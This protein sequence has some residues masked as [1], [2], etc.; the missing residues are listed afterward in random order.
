MD[1]GTDKSSKEIIKRAKQE[2]ARLIELI[3]GYI[4]D[5]LPAVMN[6]S[7]MVS[8]LFSD[9]SNGIGISFKPDENIEDIINSYTEKLTELIEEL[10]KLE[11]NEE[12][13]INGSPAL[14]KAQKIEGIFNQSLEEVKKNFYNSNKGKLLEDYANTEKIKS[15][16]TELENQRAY[17]K[18]KL[19]ATKRK[20]T[21]KEI[22]QQ[23]ANL[24]RKIGVLEK[25]LSGT[26]FEEDV[27]VPGLPK[28]NL[29]DMKK[30]KIEPVE[31]NVK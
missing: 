5:K 8:E 27:K 4:T 1:N 10:K 21:K 20:K 16:I 14:E 3:G 25:R 13:I 12:T 22:E 11:V 26:E 24:D 29:E 30:N 17:L 31:E 23:I 9:I 18:G 19:D 7:K 6:D 28:L 2:K 15:E